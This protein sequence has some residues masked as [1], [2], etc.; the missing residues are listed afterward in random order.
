[1]KRDLKPPPECEFSPRKMKD[2]IYVIVIRFNP[3]Q[4]VQELV[5]FLVNDLI[6]VVVKIFEKR[7]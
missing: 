1:M 2:E 3:E 7:S 6:E 4:S 5:S